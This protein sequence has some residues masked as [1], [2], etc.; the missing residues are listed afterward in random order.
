MCARE[1]LAEAIG[2]LYWAE[3]YFEGRGGLAGGG[4]GGLRRGGGSEKSSRIGLG[5]WGELA[6]NDLVGYF[7][8]VVTKFVVKA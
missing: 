5:C 3:I 2:E 1:P 8:S 4:G 6:I 7:L